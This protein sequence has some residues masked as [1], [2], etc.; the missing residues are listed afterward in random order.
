MDNQETAVKEEIN[1]L[2]KEAEKKENGTEEEKKQAEGLK[3]TIEEMKKDLEVMAKDKL[4]KMIAEKAK[5]ANVKKQMAKIEEE[6]RKVHPKVKEA[7]HI[8]QTLNRKIK[9]SIKMEKVMDLATNQSTG[10]VRPVI[11]VNNDEVKYFYEWD[12]S[13]FEQRFFLIKEYLEDFMDDGILQKFSKDND[14]FWDPMPAVLIGIVQCPL[15]PLKRLAPSVC[16]NGQI[17]SHEKGQQESVARGKLSALACLCDEKGEALKP[18]FGS[19][20]GKDNIY[21][22]IRVQQGNML[23]TGM[24]DMHVKYRF[25]WEKN[26]TETKKDP[27]KNNMNPVWDF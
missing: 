10:K 14:P 27:K 2:Q 15:L 13:K 24:M 9:F 26:I 6:L 16:A 5:L 25:G 12:V 20:I 17:W 3:K 21:V 23:P 8:A 4:S 19:I 1:N 7:N 18:E 22:C 11:V